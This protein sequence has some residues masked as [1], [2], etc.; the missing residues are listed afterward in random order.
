MAR[1]EL[2]YRL[3]DR[4]R[5]EQLTGLPLA[6]FRRRF[7]AFFVDFFIL[8][9]IFFATVSALTPYFMKYGLMDPEKDYNLQFGFGNWYSIIFIVVYF[10]L[11]H[12][13]GNGRTLGKRIFKIR[14][15]SVTHEKLDFGHCLEGAF[16]YGASALEAGLGFLQ[17]M[18]H[19]DRLAT[20]DRIAET[21]VVSEKKTKEHTS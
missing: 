10:T 4:S 13:W 11:G 9:M 5:A 20:H 7:A 3:K 16:G 17:V 1:K 14:V 21:I 8:A 15:I 18:W 2:V 19:D 6:S 12:F